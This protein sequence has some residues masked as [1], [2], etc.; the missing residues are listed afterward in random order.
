[1]AIYTFSKLFNFENVL[2]IDCELPFLQGK[3]L[4][5]ITFKYFYAPDFADFHNRDRGTLRI[6]KL[7]DSISKADIDHD[8]LPIEIQLHIRSLCFQYIDQNHL[9]PYANIIPIESYPIRWG[10]L[11]PQDTARKAEVIPFPVFPEKS[12]T[13]A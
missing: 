7:V 9:E 12:E 11:D 13:Q 10:S 1:M 6:L 4:I 3:Q 8:I 2:S 5:A